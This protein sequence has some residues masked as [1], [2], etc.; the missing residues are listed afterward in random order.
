MKRHRGNFI[1]RT[2]GGEDETEPGGE[3]N[4]GVPYKS[5]GKYRSG[6][7]GSERKKEARSRKEYLLMGVEFP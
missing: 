1:K 6:V 5:E 2:W 7:P 3:P 4:M